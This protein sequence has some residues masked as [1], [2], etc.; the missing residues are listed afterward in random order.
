MP[1]AGMVY[2]SRSSRATRARSQRIFSRRT[3]PLQ[4]PKSTSSWKPIRLPA[5][6]RSSC[7][8]FAANAMRLQLLRSPTIL[9]PSPHACKTGADQGL[10][11][12]ELEGEA[13]QDR[14]EGVS[15]TLC[16][17]PNGE[18]R[19]PTTNVPGDIVADRGTTAAATSRASV[20]RSIVT[21]SRAIDRRN[22]SR[23]Q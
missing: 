21:R 16:S 8:T 19:H 5:R 7:R 6:T 4:Y 17:L 10:V 18:G 14:R 2:S 1:M 15:R 20:K 22:A 12:D 3:R 23:Y 11:T 13:D 9:A